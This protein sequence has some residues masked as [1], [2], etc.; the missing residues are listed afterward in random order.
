MFILSGMLLFS[1][2]DVLIRM[3]ASEGSLVQIMVFRG[4]LG[5]L[6]LMAFL[7][8]TGRPIRIG[9][10]YPVLALIRILLFFSG[11]LAFY[12]A[13]SGM[14]L[15]EATSLFF[16]SPIFITIISKLVFKSDVG[17]YRG[18]AIVGGFAGV[19]M[20]IKPSPGQFNAIAL[21][22]VFTALGYAIAMMIARH[23]RDKDTIFQ[24]MLQLYIG[25]A[26]FGTVAALALNLLGI[27]AD[28]FPELDYLV[29]SWS[30]DNPFLL[31]AMATVAAFGSLG[32]LLLTSAYRVGSPPVLAP[33]EYSLLLLASLFGYLLFDEIPDLLSGIGMVT[34]VASGLFIFIREGVR[35]KPLA[36]KTSLRT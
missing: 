12:F 34:I 35:R 29:R 26:V 18:A 21:L 22:P 20:I 33:F 16:V 25:S 4:L 9:S 30:F 15:A 23:T 32:M 27:D 17:W 10:A 7:R 2:Q 14:S 1:V 19:L 31:L 28:T 3:M 11:F 5:C 24:Q 36:V 13:L 8:L 6:V